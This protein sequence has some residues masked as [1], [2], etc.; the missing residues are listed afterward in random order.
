VWMSAFFGVKNFGSFEI[1]GVSERTRGLSQCGHFANKG[2]GESIFRDFVRTSF[3]YGPFSNRWSLQYGV[4]QQC[5]ELVLT[6][7]VASISEWGWGLAGFG[8][9]TPAVGGDWRSGGFAAGSKGVWE[10]GPSAGRFLQFFNKNNIYLC[11]FRP[12]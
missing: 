1:Y 12:K 9:G 2:R 3:M 5:A 11:I 8:G 6:S 10:R 4:F 7:G